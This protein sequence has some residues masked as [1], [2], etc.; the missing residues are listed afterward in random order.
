[1]HVALRAISRLVGTPSPLQRKRTQR[2]A[3]E[4]GYGYV[5]AAELIAA[6]KSVL[7]A[8]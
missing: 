2:A 5:A 3:D 1:M 7:A 4:S 8:R 6:Y